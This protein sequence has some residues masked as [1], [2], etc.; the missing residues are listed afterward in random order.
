MNL[1]TSGQVL[2]EFYCRVTAGRL[3]EGSHSTENLALYVLIIKDSTPRTW[4][5][6][7]VDSQHQLPVNDKAQCPRKF[8]TTS[9]Y[10]CLED[11]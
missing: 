5:T 2:N 4:D 10:P 6:T 8:Q 1:N 9:L 11:T 3:W 7:P